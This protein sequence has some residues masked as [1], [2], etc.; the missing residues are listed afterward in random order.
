MTKNLH[1]IYIPGLGDHKLDSQVRVVRFWRHYGVEPE[2]FRM[3]WG[4]KEPWQPKFERLLARIDE[5]RSQNKGVALVG[6]SAGASA[7]INAFAA[8]KDVIKGVVLIA[9]KVNHPETIH[10]GHNDNNPAF[11]TSAQDC[12]Q[13]LKNLDGSE[14]KRIMSRFGIYDEIVKSADSRIPA[15]R[16]RYVPAAFHVVIITTQITLGAPSLLRFLKRLPRR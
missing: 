14:R 9:G 15:A 8:R 16:N 10:P 13:A 3:N 2:I 6:I 4:D 7:A 1:V 11:V 12:Q 5:L